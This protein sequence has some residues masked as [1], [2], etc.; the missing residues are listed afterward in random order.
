M[1]EL[2]TIL[3]EISKLF[4]FDY[5]DSFFEYLKSISK[6]NKQVCNKAVKQGEGGYKCLDCEI[7]SLSLICCDCFNKN[8]EKHKGHKVVF[9]P[10]N[11]G[12]CD[13]GDPNTI[14]KEGFCPDHQG[15]FTNEKSIMDFIKS[16]LS[17]EINQLNPVLNKIFELF[18]DKIDKINKIEDEEEIIS[19]M[20]ELFK[21]ID[22]FYQLC[23]KLYKSNLGF[24]YLVTLKCTENFPF[25]TKHKCFNYNE[26]DKLITI[27]KESE[28]EYHKCI[29][30]FFQILIQILLIKKTQYDSDNFFSLFIQNY[31]NKIISG[32]SFFH[33]FINLHLND[34]L[35]TFRGMAYQLFSDDLSIVIFEEKNKFFLEN[36]FDE[37]YKTI[38]NLI[39]DEQ[40]EKIQNIIYNLLI[41][42]KYL[43]KAHLVDKISSNLK[44][45]KQVIDILSLFN[46]LN[47]FK[48]CVH[49]DIFQR[50]GL[51]I[52]LLNCE[53]FSLMISQI[54]TFLLDYN[55]E[56]HVKFIFDILIQKLI[57][58]KTD[59]ENLG[60]KIFSFHIII[61]RI[62]SIFLNRFCFHYSIKNDWDLFDSF[63]YFQNLI[64]K[65]KE[66]NEFLFK[67]LINLFS[68]LI[69]Q[70]YSY[71]YF[72][73]EGMV[74]LFRNYFSGRIYILC[75]IT[76]MKYL[77]SISEMKD[78]FNLI[79]ILQTSKIDTILDFFLNQ[80]L[81]YN[82]DDLTKEQN[83]ELI[84]KIQDNQKCLA[85]VNS[86]FEF[87][88]QIIRDN[89]SMIHLCFKF[90]DLLR[91]KYIDPILENISKK[92][93]NFEKI[94]EYEML[95]FILGNKN[96]I[97]REKCIKQ[98]QIYKDYFTADTIDKILSEKCEEISSSN[99]LKQ[100]S[101]KKSEFYL[102]DLDYII[103]YNQR[104]NTFKYMMD[105]KSNNY[106]FLNT[107]FPPSLS[108]QS[109]LNQ[110]IFENFFNQQNLE[111]IE[112]LFN[113]LT[114][115]QYYLELNE[116]FIYIISKFIC[117][118]IKLYQ[119]KNIDEN[120][121]N[122]ISESIKN[123]KLEDTNF[124]EYISYIKKL[125]YNEEEVGKD[126]SEKNKVLTSNKMSLKN[127]FKQKFNQQ[128]QKFLNKYSDVDL[129][130]E[131]ENNLNEDICI[132][133][134]IHLN[135]NDL[136]NYY[137]IICY[138]ISDFFNDI[139]MKKEQ[140][141][142]KKTTRFVTCN[143][144][145]HFECYNKFI[146]QTFSN[147]FL[148]QKGFS[149]PLCKK[150]SNIILCDFNSLIT[151]NKDY[152]KGLTFNNN[153]LD[154]FYKEDFTPNLI[155]PNKNLFEDYLSKIFK[156]KDFLLTDLN[157]EKNDIE[158]IYNSILTD[159][160][161]FV[162]YYSITT[163]KNEQIDI[164]KN[165]LLTIRFLCKSKS[166]N[167]I[168]YFILK[169]QEIYKNFE[170]FNFSYFN[171][172]E[173]T[174]FVDGLII[175]LLILYDLNEENKEK[176]K[177]LFR[178]NILLFYYIY[179]YL[180]NKET[181]F[182]EYLEKKEN[183]D[184]F[185]KIFYLYNLKYK[186]CF[187]FYN[188]KEENLNLDFNE[189][190]NSMKNNENIKKLL[191]NY[192][193]FKNKN[194][195]IILK[196]QI[197]E[198]P[199]FDIIQL[200]E[201]FLDFSSYY[202]NIK[203]VNCKNKNSNSYVCLIC[204]SKICNLKSCQS[205]IN[206]KGKKEYSLIEHSKRC[207]GENTIFISI[208]NSEIIYLLKRQFIFPKIYIYLNSF[209]EYRKD[210]Y[211]TS[212]FILNKIELDKAIKTYINI[213]YR[214]R[215][216]RILSVNMTFNFNYLP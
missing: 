186:I 17:I 102:C 170:D 180:K 55:N 23:S 198:I 40:Y 143:H 74:L 7:D 139:L 28:S 13:C 187:L 20:D 72:F 192:D 104:I 126:D 190:I 165:F 42:L 86:Y 97:S 147:S 131:D 95:L 29:C 18:I 113:I 43:P 80:L 96:L 215:G 103:D 210:S 22:C 9:H 19:K 121:K 6:P 85:F 164:W 132:F 181:N 151:N 213:T 64:P 199:H 84:T 134:R 65:S 216:Y 24:F 129:E 71:F 31:K 188:E 207:S 32:I 201:N 36:F 152:L 184:L 146:I 4:G 45:F 154:N 75:D 115:N 124:I 112:N 61:I 91:M 48:D 122:I 100:F 150:L 133:C 118:Y 167:L 88:L 8:K 179:P 206:I 174:Y 62:Y 59:K 200:P 57:D 205:E 153:N 114:M 193:N 197:F 161:S 117:V 203:C 169:F 37:C 191:T 209:G 41:I 60:E 137:G 183:E 33:T 69:A 120:F 142:R 56:T 125:L 25:E 163:N 99:Q 16:C 50:D 11:Y 175:C 66:L 83:Q 128:N 10:E 108:I 171:N 148:L 172:L 26:E 160:N 105:F 78:Q 44:M 204:G 123:H 101:L 70:K 52:N 93:K 30:P 138:K 51:Q 68:F 58:F 54:L 73:G 63:E 79:E 94:I 87:I 90:T 155:H 21:M 81:I 185:K 176:I 15:P 177:K 196:E 208:I 159:F 214:Q 77:L 106:S 109:K 98:Y 140:N 211:L 107:Y 130:I 144:K 49:Y 173:I 82:K 12:Y 136:N 39:E 111:N 5:N 76:L 149:C 89:T 34:N 182:N 202:S 3:N 35:T 162:N 194:P 127:K 2:T 92:E 145:I 135:K 110:K 27:I 156:K 168:E 46:N 195:N 14:K 119:D 141:Q 212:D 1:N 158:K 116:I 189:S 38:K 157:Y 166:I 178:N 47:Y 53:I 67:E